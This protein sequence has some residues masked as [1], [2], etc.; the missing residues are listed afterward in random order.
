MDFFKK[1]K[2]N[3]TSYVC[4]FLNDTVGVPLSLYICIESL[5]AAYGFATVGKD[6]QNLTIPIREYFKKTDIAWIR[7][8]VMKLENESKKFNTYFNKRSYKCPE[9]K[10]NIFNV[11]S[12]EAASELDEKVEAMEFHIPP[13]LSPELSASN[14]S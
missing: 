7:D 9:A 4:P 12:F 14:N 6:Y 2:K 13:A 8:F 1:F 5:E 11:S 3:H 10:Q